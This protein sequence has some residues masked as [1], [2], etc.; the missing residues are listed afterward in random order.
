MHEVEVVNFWQVSL[1]LKRVL[2]TFIG[3]ASNLGD[4]IGQKASND[5]KHKQ[6]GHEYISKDRSC[7]SCCLISSSITKAELSTPFLFSP[8]LTTKYQLF[9]SIFKPVPLIYRV[10]MFNLPM[11]LPW[12]G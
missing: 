8:S 11:P 6:N 10:L 1:L 5:T 9:L 4:L 12:G 7:I 2:F 3:K